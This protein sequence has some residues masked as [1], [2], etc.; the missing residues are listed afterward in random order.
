MSSTAWVLTDGK[1][2]DEAPCLGVIE[3]LGLGAEL[4][5][6]EPRAPF[7]WAMPW[8]PIDP[9]ERALLASS[10]IAPGPA[11]WPDLVVAS[12]RRAVP[13]LREVRRRSGGRSFTVFLRD[14]RTGAGAADLI[15]VPEHDRLRGANVIAT[16]TTPHR[17][18]PD[19]LAAARV[20][21]H[22][23]FEALSPPRAAVLLGG[24]SRRVR[25]GAADEARLA[26]ALTTLAAS[27]VALAVT[28]S[29]RTSRSLHEAVA[30]VARAS[31]GFFWDGTGENPLVAMLAGAD[32]IVVSADSVNM[33]SE[34]VATGTP[35]LVF[36]L[37]DLPPRHRAFL[38]ALLGIGAIRLFT[39]RP[40]PYLYDPVDSTPVIADAI[41]DAMAR[42]RTAPSIR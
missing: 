41:R 2:G 19:R 10:P 6:V 24:P 37:A 40:D 16:V 39:G 26:V 35:V 36:D 23:R 33:I 4:R 32:M 27:G 28:A 21:G 12:G 5:R 42:R 14:P 31:G 20:A 22:R 17:L 29:R 30:P 1:A 9:R 34:A 3:R 11:G 7:T 8:G 38:D 13:Y 25:F 15:W 18:A